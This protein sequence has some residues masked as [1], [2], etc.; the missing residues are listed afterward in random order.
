MDLLPDS[1]NLGGCTLALEVENATQ[2][3][4]VCIFGTIRCQT[5]EN[6]NIL[7]KELS[8]LP[9]NEIDEFLLTM[10]FERSISLSERM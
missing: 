5:T 1:S 3:G 9:L 7:R 8:T 2:S 6:P 4:K 10:N